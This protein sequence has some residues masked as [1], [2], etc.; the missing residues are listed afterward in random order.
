[1]PW[2]RSTDKVLAL[3]SSC[4]VIIFDTLSKIFNAVLFNIICYLLLLQTD[5][6]AFHT[7]AEALTLGCYATPAMPLANVLKELFPGCIVLDLKLVIPPPETSINATLQTGVPHCLN[8]GY[9]GKQIDDSESEALLEANASSDT[10]KNAGKNAGGSG[11]QRR[12][13]PSSINADQ[14]PK[15]G[16][17]PAADQ[18]VRHGADRGRL[19]QRVLLQ[20]KLG[21]KGRSRSRSPLS[22]D[23][24]VVLTDH[25][26]PNPPP[27][28][29]PTMP[30]LLNNPNGYLLTPQSYHHYFEPHKPDLVLVWRKKLAHMSLPQHIAKIVCEISSWNKEGRATSLQRH[31]DEAT[32]QC[33]QS[34]LAALAHDQKCILGIVIVADGLK[35]V[36]IDR[37][38]GN[39]SGNDGHHTYYTVKETRLVHWNS[40]QD[41]YVLFGMIK[42][43]I[44]N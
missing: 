31:V 38:S 18:N 32:E 12:A 44:L 16:G 3:F 41:L 2:E 19:R 43:V 40:A 11:D 25:V 13:C 10:G 20:K 6:E 22:D 26:L 30:R 5:N 28:G 4:L 34:C 9:W 24:D 17:D 29:N 27:P 35:L 37:I 42:N 21:R 33:V 23:D 15:R 36:K 7:W 8:Y 39:Q 1:M 14:N